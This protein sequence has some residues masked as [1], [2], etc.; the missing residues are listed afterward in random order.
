MRLKTLYMYIAKG[1]LSLVMIYEMQRENLFLHVFLI[2]RCKT[3]EP[4]IR[5]VFYLLHLANCGYARRTFARL[6]TKLSVFLIR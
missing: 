4:K 1:F 2:Y 5:P 3:T 6:Q